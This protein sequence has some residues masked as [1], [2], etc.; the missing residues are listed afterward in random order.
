MDRYSNGESERILGRAIRELK[1]NRQKIVIA[2]KGFCAVTPKELNRYVG[3]PEPY[4]PEF[5]N[6]YGLSRKHLFDAVDASLERLGLD[7]IDLVNN[8]YF[9][10]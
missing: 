1:M 8:I 6:E 5:I 10:F 4:D 7:Y 2:T 9:F 3:I